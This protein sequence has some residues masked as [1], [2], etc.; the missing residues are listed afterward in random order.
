IGVAWLFWLNA[1]SFIVILVVW[2]VTPVAPTPRA[3]ERGVVAATAAATRWVRRTPAV[4]AVILTTFVVAGVGQVYQPLSVAFTT[5]VLA[6]GNDS[7]GASYYGIFQ[8][9]IGV[10][11]AVGILGMTVMARRQPRRTFVASTVGCAA[12]LFLLGFTHVLLLA[13]LVA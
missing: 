4:A 12:F 1:A 2:W 9:A 10:G 13:L 7:T 3:A 8:A 11:S 6:H 5:T